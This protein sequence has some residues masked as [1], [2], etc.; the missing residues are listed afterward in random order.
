MTPAARYQAS[1]ELWDKIKTARVPM[2]GVCGD[3]FRMR[4]FIGSKDR[5]EIAERA[6]N[7]MRAHARL[8]WWCTHLGLEHTSR[9][10]VILTA[11]LIDGKTAQ[12]LPDYF[13][14][15][16]YHPDILSEDEVNAIQKC[17]TL[18]HTDMPEDVLT[19]CPSWAYARLKD[20][21]G[22]TYTDEMA[23]MLTPANLDI[24]VNT[25]KIDRGNAGALLAKDDIETT[26]CPYSP[27][28]LRLKSKAYLAHSKA[29][30]KG[31]IEI[32]DEGSQLLALI[33][34]AKPGDQVLDYCAG[35]GGKTLALA[36][37][38]Q[39]KGRIV[40]MDIEERRLAKSKPRLTKADVHNV[41]LRPILDDKHRKWFKR[42]KDKFDVVLIDA[43]C[44]SSG[45]WRR[46][47]DLKWHHFGPSHN[48][49]QAMQSDILSRVHASTK[50]GGRLIYATCSLFREENEHQVEAF[51]KEN[52]NFKLI[53]APQVWAE[54]GMKTPC[55]VKGN[56]LRLTPA[57]HKTDG[58]FAAVLERVE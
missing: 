1:I 52:K 39:G 44:S 32:Q 48:D 45:T 16:K 31:L 18:D 56:Y 12:D 14:G 2:D 53:P 9:S 55:P 10:L 6:Y 27:V 20:L 49:I 29:F 50:I 4:R 11:I 3:Y 36:A 21:F 28:G 15:N 23:A 37:Q 42:Q 51:L 40:A 43:P 25:L 33:C 38:M 35:G 5:A 46:N 41:E 34:N 24:R 47:P 58:F 57:Q 22:D 30:K 8:L 7:M 19:E 26:P 54:T 17:T 13:N